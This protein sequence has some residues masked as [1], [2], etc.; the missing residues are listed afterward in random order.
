MAP[1]T[2]IS[3][4]ACLRFSSDA[5]E[6]EDRKDDGGD[7]VVPIV[8]AAG[9]NR[10]MPI[11]VGAVAAMI[12][13]AIGWL[14]ATYDL[15]GNEQIDQ[16]MSEETSA[17][18]FY[19]QG[20]TYP[21]GFAAER[22]NEFLPRTESALVRAV[23][24]PD[25]SN[26]GFSLAGGRIIPGPRGNAITYPYERGEGTDLEKMAVHVWKSGKSGPDMEASSDIQTAQ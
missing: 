24:P 15:P 23:D 1:F 10:R 9:Q 6:K 7:V 19:L 20:P 14:V 21:I 2:R 25:L 22:I 11:L 18:S 8:V 17:F 13:V 26:S 12:G 5:R 3:P 4:T 16:A